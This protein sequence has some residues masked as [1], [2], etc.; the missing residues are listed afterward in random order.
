[1]SVD[2]HWNWDGSCQA[3][4]NVMS[5]KNKVCWRY[6][7][8][9]YQSRLSLG[10]LLCQ[11]ISSVVSY[12]GE[13]LCWHG[14]NRYPAIIA[15]GSSWLICGGDRPMACDPLTFLDL[16][17]CTQKQ[18]TDSFHIKWHQITYMENAYKN[19]KQQQMNFTKPASSYLTTFLC[20]SDLRWEISRMAVDGTPSMSLQINDH[21]FGNALPWR[22]T[23]PGTRIVGTYALRRIF[24][25]ATRLPSSLCF[26][27]Y[28]IP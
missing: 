14:S 23:I 20:L 27:L 28:T 26:A 5:S 17:S 13:W 2:L 10:N 4:R 11:L 6:G 21:L 19:E 16:G 22:F 18:G 8:V 12:H 7:N 3:C 15:K 9:Q 24:L 1:M 25:R